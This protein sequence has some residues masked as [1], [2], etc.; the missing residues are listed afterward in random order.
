MLLICSLL[1][2]YKLLV[3]GICFRTGLIGFLE[4]R[5]HLIMVFLGQLCVLC[6]VIV[7]L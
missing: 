2:L 6:D 5:N 7:V 3:S 1:G 4:G